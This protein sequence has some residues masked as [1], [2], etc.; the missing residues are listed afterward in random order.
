MLERHT[1]LYTCGEVVIQVFRP[2][3]SLLHGVNPNTV[4]LR[5][6]YTVG[7]LYKVSSCYKIYHLE[8]AHE[9]TRRDSWLSAMQ[10]A[11][12]G[13]DESFSGV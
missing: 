13:I 12:L 11:R 6:T 10:V 8:S 2:L 9:D 5:T 7:N 4:K 3:F 1:T